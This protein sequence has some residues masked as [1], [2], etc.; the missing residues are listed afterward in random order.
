MPAI[1][2]TT[3][4]NLRD[5]GGT[6]LGRGRAVRPGLV[7]RSGQLDRLDPAADPA[8]AALGVRTVIDLR[9]DAER[10][11]YP[12]RVPEAVR[13][14]TADAL[15]DMLATSGVRPAA[16]RL[17][18][19][20]AD[21]VLAERWLGGGRA[22]AAFEDIYRA[23]VTTDSARAAYRLLLTELAAPDAGPLLFH[24]SAGKDRTG[25]GTSVLLMLLGAD[26]ES[27]EREYLSVNTAVRHVF[28]PL[29]EGFA[30][31]GGDPELALAVVGVLPAYLRAGLDEVATRYGTVE[32]YVREGL[33]VPDRAVDRIRE[34][35]TAPEG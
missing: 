1:P 17:R 7:F 26:E 35:L 19:L 4:A 8:F 21:P 13:V 32:A 25:W 30:A 27:V 28:A 12:D 29:V 31:Q 20:L 10:A 16:T 11:A 22:Q 23:L 14:L 9:T 5:L 33:G 34:R 15:G 2:A 18:E 24:C 3:V 6:P